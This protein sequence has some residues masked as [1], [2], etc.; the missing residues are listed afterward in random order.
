MGTRGLL[1]FVLSLAVIAYSG[2]GH[3][4]ESIVLDLKECI[5]RALEL[6]PQVQEAEYEAKVYEGKRA[7]ADAARYPQIEILAITA[8][9][10]RARGDQVMSPD[11]S[12]RPV[13][14]GVFGK[15]EITIIQPLYT[16][17]KISNLRKAAEGGVKASRAAVD[18]KASDIILR[19]KQLYYSILLA[20]NMEK[21][22]RGIREE[23]LGALKKIER[24]LSIG[25]PWV[26]E[27][28]RY[29]LN[30]FL[31]IVDK[32]LEE[33]ENGLA[34]AKDALRTSLGIPAGVE[35]D[36][37]EEPFLPE[38]APVI[39]L[40]EGINRA[41]L[42]RPEFIQLREGIKARKA[43][44]DAERSNYY[45][46]LFIG[47]KGSIASASNRDRLHNPF[48]FDEFNHSYGAL[49]LGLKWA[50]DFGITKGRVMEAEAEYRK[51]LERKRL[52]EEGIPFEVRRAYLDLKKAQGVIKATERAYR[53]AKKW[54]VVAVANFDMGVGEAKEIADALQMYALS[55]ADYLRAIYNEKISYANL[56]RVTGMDVKE[57]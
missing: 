5:A 14:S 54:L 31:G 41:R 28:D 3:A 12:A 29:K 48:V 49:Y 15:G 8:P 47:M 17:G 44:V 42:L 33:V 7:Q 27:A 38:E 4:E 1:G 36:I 10:P 57:R 9:S 45:P 40:E 51:L 23:I 20:K 25:S 55:R 6:S 24:H 19:T 16:F 34:V 21:H 11:D 13:L 22:I 37:K 35:F 26:D 43:L 53:N 2:D 39:S 30:T 18:R 56:Y 32:N 46:V 52:A 50:I